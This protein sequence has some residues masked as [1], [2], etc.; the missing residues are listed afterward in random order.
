MAPKLFWKMIG[1]TDDHLISETGKQHVK[2]IGEE[3]LIL[4]L[5]HIRIVYKKLFY[6]MQVHNQAQHTDGLT[7]QTIPVADWN[8]FGSLHMPS[9]Q[10]LSYTRTYE[11]T[12]C[13][14][15]VCYWE[16]WELISTEHT[17][18][19]P[20]ED[21]LTDLTPDTGAA[22]QEGLY[23]LL[24][25]PK[26]TQQPTI[27]YQ[28]TT[29]DPGIRPWKS[30][31]NFWSA[32]KLKQKAKYRLE[33]FASIKHTVYVPGFTMSHN[34]MQDTDF[35]RTRFKDISIN[36]MT[37]LIGEKCADDANNHQ[38]NSYMPAKVSVRYQDSGVWRMRPTGRKSF[39]IVT[40]SFAS[41]GDAVLHNEW[42]YPVAT[43]PAVAMPSTAFVNIEQHRRLFEDANVDD[44]GVD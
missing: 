29:L 10:C 37:F 17:T 24:G 40:N 41:I 34:S 35:N 13:S 11:I 15:T 42:R 28:H 31:K 32:W 6:D 3:W 12:N 1:A 14:S 36:C 26:N 21:W 8:D 5:T 22:G 33:P 19:N 23:G 20:Q 27:E 30:C 7:A 18:R 4:L 44:N 43:N 25:L 2:S 38:Y 16:I 9:L 39:S